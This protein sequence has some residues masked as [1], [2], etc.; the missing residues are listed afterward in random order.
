MQTKYVGIKQFRQELA[1]LHARAVKNNWRYV[2]LSRNQPLF[3]VRPL[4]ANDT[5]TQNFMTESA[6]AKKKKRPSKEQPAGRVDV[7]FV[8]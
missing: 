5:E 4:T 2:V 6:M 7:L 3:D 1:S 8:A